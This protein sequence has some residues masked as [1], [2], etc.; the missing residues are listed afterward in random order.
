MNTINTTP[1]LINAY[2]APSLLLR[3]AF[4]YTQNEKVITPNITTRKGLISCVNTEGGN[5]ITIAESAKQLHTCNRRKK[6]LASSGYKC[7]V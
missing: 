7:F 3:M 5:M 2:K 6:L 1:V 4:I